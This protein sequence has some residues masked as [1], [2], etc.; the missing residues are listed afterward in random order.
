M[1][2]AAVATS[3]IFAPD[4]ERIVIRAGDQPFRVL[5]WRQPVPED[6]EAAEAD[7][8]NAAAQRR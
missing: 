8:A 2:N 5:T 6:E 3:T 7:A 4:E 1:S